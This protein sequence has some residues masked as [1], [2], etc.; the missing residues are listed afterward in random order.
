M[1]TLRVHPSVALA[2]AAGG[3][4]LELDKALLSPDTGLCPLSLLA[5]AFFYQVL[6]SLVAQLKHTLPYSVEEV[7]CS[8][9]EI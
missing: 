9:E 2:A 4:L 8:F 3:K 7:G 5:S 6:L 1:A